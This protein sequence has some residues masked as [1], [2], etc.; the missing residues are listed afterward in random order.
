VPGLTPAGCGVKESVCFFCRMFLEARPAQLFE[1][2]PSLS[3]GD[4]P[5][6]GRAVLTG[7]A[8]LGVVA[9]GKDLRNT[10]PSALRKDGSCRK[11]GRAWLGET[12]CLVA[13]AAALSP[14]AGGYNT[15]C[16]HP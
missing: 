10:L 5:H 14:V 15:G 16:A 6:P 11:R 2:R 3:E 7:G 12:C 4:C 13:G 9:G 1:R 8:R